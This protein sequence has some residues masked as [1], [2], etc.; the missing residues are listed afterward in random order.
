[1][2]KMISGTSDGPWPFELEDVSVGWWIR[3]YSRKT[4]SRWL[5]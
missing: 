1:M 4:Y 3:I 5:L 2:I